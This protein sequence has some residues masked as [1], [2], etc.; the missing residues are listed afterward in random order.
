MENLK[1]TEMPIIFISITH[2]FENVFPQFMNF[3]SRPGE[4]KFAAEIL[5]LQKNAAPKGV[6]H[7]SADYFALEAQRR[8]TSW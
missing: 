6:R 8:V 1:T 3:S 2:F 4:S 5:L 7:R